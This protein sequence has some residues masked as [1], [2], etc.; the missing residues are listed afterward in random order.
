M[1]FDSYHLGSGREKRRGERA[2]AGADIEHQLARQYPGGGH[3]SIGP[4]VSQFVISPPRPS[5][6]GHGAP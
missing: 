6:G 3:Q 5:L 4:A 2:S 1:K